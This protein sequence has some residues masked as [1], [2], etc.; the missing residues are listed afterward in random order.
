MERLVETGID[1]ELSIQ[2]SR[3][4]TAERELYEKMK[5]AGVK[6][7]FYGIESGCQDV[8]DL[9]NKG[10]TL[11]QIRRA[12]NLAHEMGFFITG[13]F[14]LGA[15]IETEK[16]IEQSIKFA[17]SLPF[18]FTIWHRLIYKYGSDI[19]TEAA[20]AGK[21]T[22]DDGYDVMTD[23]QRGLG[24]FTKEE[25]EEFCKKA[26]RRFHLRPHYIFQGLSRMIVK[27]DFTLLKAGLEYL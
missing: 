13:S 16:H 5:K 10:T 2:G 20:A 9:Y 17:C 4:D 6:S 8:L 24:N 23:S 7:I 19:W 25:L 18:D 11:D 15:P 21:I 14:I 3:V 27:R 1:L 26:F 22:E 12:A